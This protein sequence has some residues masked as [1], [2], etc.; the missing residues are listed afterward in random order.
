MSS[1]TVA[2]RARGLA[3]ADVRSQ[4]VGTLVF[5]KYLFRELFNHTRQIARA[6]YEYNRIQ[7]EGKQ[8]EELV[9]LRQLASH[10][11]PADV[12]KFIEAN[13]MPAWDT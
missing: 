3:E 1:L 11:D 13:L 12:S 2:L 6:R 7:E 9:A 8:K 10:F 4:V 5:S